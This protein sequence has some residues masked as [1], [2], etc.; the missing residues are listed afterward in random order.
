MPDAPAAPP[1][2]LAEAA[3]WIGL[4]LEDAGGSRVGRVRRVFADTENGLPT[5]LI[6][7]LGRW[8]SKLVP[9][10]AR[11]C[12]ATAD[13]VWV[14]HDRETLQT[15]PIIDAG[16]PL[17]REH[18]LA[19]CAHYGIGHGVGRASETRGRPEGS[20]TSEPAV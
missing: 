9:V 16:R 5:W 10:P 4:D 14:A 7:S 8:R 6:V 18:E 19:I 17:L 2:T 20:V 12:A 3:G 15:A 11:N 13:R 1:P